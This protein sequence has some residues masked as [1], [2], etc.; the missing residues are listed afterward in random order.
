MLLKAFSIL[1]IKTGAYSSPFFV[2]YAGQA[3][4]AAVDLG[5]D[6]NTTVGRYP[7]DFRLVRLGEFDDA[8]GL[9]LRGEHEDLGTIGSLLAADDLR[10]ADPSKMTAAEV[11]ALREREAS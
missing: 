3:L 9:L 6:I 10:R 1:D 11:V 5:H 4:R 2:Q 8:V 7:F